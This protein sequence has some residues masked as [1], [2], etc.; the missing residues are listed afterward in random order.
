MNSII[1]LL[2]KRD[3]ENIIN[4]KYYTIDEIQSINYLNQ[5]DALNFFHVNMCSLSKKFEELL[6]E[7]ELR[8][9]IVQ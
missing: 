1:F 2:S 3:T 5:K 8:K 4:C 6:V 9:I 7:Q